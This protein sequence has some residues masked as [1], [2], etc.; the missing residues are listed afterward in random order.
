MA[1]RAQR[2]EGM[3]SMEEE[4]GGGGA[5]SKASRHVAS[6]TAAGAPSCQNMKCVGIS[7]M[8]LRSVKIKLIRFCAGFERFCVGLKRG[9]G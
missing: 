2:I 8:Q 9:V 6:C 5:A 7:A 3:Q 1:H 4:A